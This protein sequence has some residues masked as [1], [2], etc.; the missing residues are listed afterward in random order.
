[1]LRGTAFWSIFKTTSRKIS[2][3]HNA[4]TFCYSMIYTLLTTKL[5]T[6]HRLMKS[7]PISKRG[8]QKT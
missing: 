3:M 6:G 1:M 2:S 8:Y 5:F 4:R 7:E